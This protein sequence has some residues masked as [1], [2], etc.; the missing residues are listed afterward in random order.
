MQVDPT[1]YA[2]VE[3]YKH[4]DIH[5]KKKGPGDQ[6]FGACHRIACFCLVQAFLA[7][8]NLPCSVCRP[9]AAAN[10]VRAHVP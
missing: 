10:Q 5:G 1:V 9:P 8:Y 3:K 6:L 4:M 7:Q 2:N